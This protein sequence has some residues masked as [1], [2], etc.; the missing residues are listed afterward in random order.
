MYNPREYEKFTLCILNAFHNGKDHDLTFYV[1]GS[2]GKKITI[3]NILNKILTRNMELGTI[4]ISMNFDLFKHD[5]EDQAKK[6]KNFII[7]ISN[8]N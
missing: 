6:N 7:L 3:W 4:S 5:I 2:L 1:T 8:S